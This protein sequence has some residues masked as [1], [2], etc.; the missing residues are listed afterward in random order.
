MKNQALLASALALGLAAPA[1]AQEGADRARL[2]EFAVPQ[3]G[4]GSAIEQVDR[5]ASRIGGEQ[6][7]SNDRQLAVPGPARP[8]REPLPQLSRPDEGGATRQ[9]SDP[10]LSRDVAAGSVSSSRDSRPQATGALAGNDRCD[11]QAR[12]GQPLCDRIL[13]RRAAEFAA[14]EPP[15]LSAEQVLLAASDEDEDALAASSSRV[16]LRLASTDDPDADLQS[17]QE[18]AAI[19]LRRTSEQP[20][21]PEDSEPAEDAALAEVLRTLQISVPGSPAP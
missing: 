4:S 1:W 12:S 5:G 18:L 21:Q 13:E 11:P 6:A 19:Y 20:Q 3:V 8:A 10:A 17:N 15:R 9:V 14:A 7:T 2:D 16:R